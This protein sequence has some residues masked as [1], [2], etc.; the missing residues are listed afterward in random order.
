MR[1]FTFFF[2]SFFLSPHPPSLHV[3]KKALTGVYRL[4]FFLMRILCTKIDLNAKKNKKIKKKVGLSQDLLGNQKKK[5]N[6]EIDGVRC[7]AFFFLFV[8]TLINLLRKVPW[9]WERKLHRVNWIK[10]NH[11][12]F[13][14][15]FSRTP[16]CF[17][18]TNCQYW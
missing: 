7:I 1:G 3:L 8:F 15:F 5:K 14:F 17:N 10:W 11:I 18:Y 6:Y 2:L 9:L 12:I 4:F 13:F 16:K